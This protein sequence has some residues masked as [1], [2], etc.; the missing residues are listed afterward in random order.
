MIKMNEKLT[1][2][3]IEVLWFQNCEKH[4]RKLEGHTGG[5]LIAPELMGHL[6]VPYTTEDAL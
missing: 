2:Q 1:A 4:F 5:N 3:F 6:A